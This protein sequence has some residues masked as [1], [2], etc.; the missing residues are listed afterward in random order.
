MRPS[1]QVLV[2]AISLALAAMAP[3]RAEP[4]KISAFG[5][6]LLYGGGR[7]HSTG[8]VGGVP[9]GEAFPAKLERA[10][11][12]KGWDAI[13]SNNSRPGRVARVAVDIVW[14]IPQ[15]TRLT[16][17]QLG[18]IDR[19]DYNASSAEIASCLD[20]IIDALH[21][22]G[23]AVVLAQRSLFMGSN[24]PVLEATAKKADLS[25]RWWEGLYLAPFVPRP[26]YDAGDGEHLNSAGTDIV[27]ARAIPDVERVLIALGLKPGS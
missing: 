22:R 27:V 18:G 24:D 13:V 19:F 12:V 16:I 26:E 20:Q 2:A 7:S 1:L 25:V 10:L 11:R 6:S 8:R 3:A 23:S 21:Q 14:Q 4:I 9:I 17:V 15:G 5:S